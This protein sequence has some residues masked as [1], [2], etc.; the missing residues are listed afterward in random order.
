MRGIV[1]KEMIGKE[2]IGK[3]TDRCLFT[4]PLLQSAV[5]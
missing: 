5:S 4:L 1:G 2:I 3:E